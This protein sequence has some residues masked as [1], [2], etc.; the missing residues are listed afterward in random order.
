MNKPLTCIYHPVY[1]SL[2]LPENHRYPI[3]KYR[4]L[5]ES[6]AQHEYL[7]DGLTIIEP[8]PLTTAQ[9]TQLHCEHYIEALFSGK[10]PA[11]KMRRIGFPWSQQ[12][13]ERTLTSAGG[14][15]E[16][17][18]QALAHGLAIHLS[19]GYHHAHHDFGSGF[20]LINDLAIAANLALNEEKIEKVMII[21][22]DVHHGD[23]TATITDNTDKIITVSAHCEKN[24]PARKPSS[25][26]DLPLDKHTSDHEYLQLL[27]QFIPLW[28]EQH[29]PDLV[30]YDAGVDI[31]I[32]DELGYCDISTKG[33]YQRDHFILAECLRREIPVAAV[34]GGGYRTEQSALVPLHQQLLCAAK[35]L[36]YQSQ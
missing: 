18:K 23:G 26:Y 24:Y 14:T 10:L 12:L 6:L 1:S 16:T 30:I 4:L 21:D 22:L 36:W 13:I 28:L 15:W 9:V 8:E 17:V 11:S 32:D 5:F 19:G 33:L 29:Q 27:H 31:H 25:S 3:Q 7:Q 20:C 35:Q 34:I 2:A